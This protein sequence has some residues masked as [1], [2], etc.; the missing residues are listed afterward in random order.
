MNSK[1]KFIIYLKKA[2]E[3]LKCYI[4]SNHFDYNFHFIKK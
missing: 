3:I 4:E 2:W 1:L